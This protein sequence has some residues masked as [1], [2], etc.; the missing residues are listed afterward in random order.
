MASLNRLVC[1]L[2]FSILL[3][4][5]A[6]ASGED[7]VRFNA[8]QNE[9]LTVCEKCRVDG[10]VCDSSYSCNITILLPDQS[11]LISQQA[12]TN[13]GSYNCYDLNTTQT[14]ING[15]YEA[16][17]DCSNTT[18]KG[19]NTFF[20]RI[21]PE[22]SPPV[23][24]GQ[25]LVLIGTILIMIVLALVMIFLGIR[26]TNGGVK[27]AFISFSILLLV[28]NIGFTVNVVN[29]FFGTSDGITSNFSTIYRLFV[30]LLSAG[31][32]AL[33]VY[34]IVIALKFFNIKRGVMDS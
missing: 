10:A 8:P 33:V 15:L 12:M 5:F 31:V 3:I 14:S 17:V 30:I 4:N 23:S 21:T 2:F 22:G 18:L 29:A 13:N 26:S 28:F 24:D 1:I 6:I 19:S 34:L 7:E 9:N 32:T 11:F 27:L 16:T 20:Y 25:G